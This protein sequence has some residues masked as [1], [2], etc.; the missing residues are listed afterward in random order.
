MDL[1]ESKYL[2]FLLSTQSI[3]KNIKNKGLE[4]EAG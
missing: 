1:L 2:F 4:M 3:A